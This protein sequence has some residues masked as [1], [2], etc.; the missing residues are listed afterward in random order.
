MYTNAENSDKG[1][2]RKKNTTRHDNKH[3]HTHIWSRVTRNCVV[4][5]RAYLRRRVWVRVGVWVCVC[6]AKRGRYITTT[7]TTTVTRAVDPQSN[8]WQ[9]CRYSDVFAERV[10]R[11]DAYAECTHPVRAALYGVR[12]SAG[13]GVF[14]SGGGGYFKRRPPNPTPNHRRTKRHRRRRHGTHSKFDDNDGGGGNN[15]RTYTRRLRN[16]AAVA[17]AAAPTPPPPPRTV[18]K[19]TAWERCWNRFALV[20][21][22]G[23][24]SSSRASIAPHDCKANARGVCYAVAFAWSS[25]HVVVIVVLVPSGRRPPPAD[26]PL[27]PISTVVGWSGRRL[28]RPVRWR[29]RRRKGRCDGRRRHSVEAQGRGHRT[30]QRWRRQRRLVS[31]MAERGRQTN[32]DGPERRPADAQDQL[33]GA[34]LLARHTRRHTSHQ[35]GVQEESH[36]QF[37]Q[38]LRLWGAERQVPDD[39]ADS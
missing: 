24:S 20:F 7:T 10:R 25:P 37:Q 21:H 3:A 29:C 28:G 38:D 31:Q 8:N 16:G 33:Q 23:S 6:M 17:A 36:D 12:L 11:A 35:Q 18:V 19:A 1:K 14:P 30:R 26:V 39:V 15:G 32:R 2:W 27:R 34:R 22:P 9:R 4:H 5:V 13:R